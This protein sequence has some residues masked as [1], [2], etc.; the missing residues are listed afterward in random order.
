MLS[1]ISLNSI[2]ICIVVPQDWIDEFNVIM[3]NLDKHIPVAY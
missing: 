2:I 1:Q 3:G